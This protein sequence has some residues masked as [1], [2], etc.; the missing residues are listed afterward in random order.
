[1]ISIIIPAYNEERILKKNISIIL[2]RIGPI[3]HENYEIIIVEEGSDNT[4]R[5]AEDLARNRKIRHIHS[6]ERLGKGG[7][8]E[9]GIVHS[10]GDKIMF[11]DIL[12][13]LSTYIRYKKP[14]R[15]GRPSIDPGP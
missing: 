5:I 14:K 10:R 13:D 6:K 15:R 4:S 3:L 12:R 1:M 9:K 8:I 7:A 11:M 2:K